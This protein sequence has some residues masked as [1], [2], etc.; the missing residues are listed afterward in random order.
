VLPQRRLQKILKLVNNSK[1]TAVFL[2]T[3]SHFQQLVLFLLI[4]EEE[5]SA[6]ERSQ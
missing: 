5:G 4:E 6:L 1:I 3:V 2:A